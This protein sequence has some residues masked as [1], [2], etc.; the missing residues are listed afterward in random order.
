MWPRRA[1]ALLVFLATLGLIALFPSST[2]VVLG[3]T[4]PGERVLLPAV[5]RAAATPTA[6]RT[7]TATATATS[8]RTPTA[9]STAVP[10]APLAAGSSVHIK[11]FGGKRIQ[12]YATSAVWA[13]ELK[14]GSTTVKPFGRFVV[15]LFDVVNL[16]LTTDWIGSGLR[17]V[18]PASGRAFD[19]ADLSAQWAAQATYPPRL[20]I[21]SDLQ[22]GITYPM[23]IVWDV[24]APA[25][26]QTIV[27]TLLS[28]RPW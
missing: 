22:P 12:V 28:L 5:Q 14:D 26:G 27:H 19:T 13:T 11:G 7:P 16:D 21:Y 1:G 17:L 2:P 23:V 25:P 10:P 8:T 24:A 6:T 20:N 15:V 4:A 9:T 3:Q 18:D